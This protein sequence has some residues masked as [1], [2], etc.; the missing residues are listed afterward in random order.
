MSKFIA[1]LS[2]Q[3]REQ[4]QD[5]ILTRYDGLPDSLISNLRQAV[6]DFDGF[7]VSAQPLNLQDEIAE[8]ARKRIKTALMLS[9]G[10]LNQAYKLLGFSNYQTLR[11][12]MNRLKVEIPGK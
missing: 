4:I 2:D 7:Y 3:I 5:D 10:R 11:N 6:A 1:E 12:W 8:L 9:N